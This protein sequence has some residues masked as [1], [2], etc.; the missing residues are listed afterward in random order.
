VHPT[1]VSLGPLRDEERGAA[2]R[3]SLDWRL[4]LGDWRNDCPSRALGCVP[5]GPAGRNPPRRSGVVRDLSLVCGAH[6]DTSRI[7]RR[8]KDPCDGR[9]SLRPRERAAHRGGRRRV[10]GLGRRR[11]RYGRRPG[12]VHR[13]SAACVHASA[14]DGR[15]RCPNDEDPRGPF[16]SHRGR[17]RTVASRRA[18]RAERGDRSS[19]ASASAAGRAFLARPMGPRR[20]DAAR[21]SAACGPVERRRRLDRGSDVRRRAILGPAPLAERH[22]CLCRVPRGRS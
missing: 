10:A 15:H 5:G 21:R 1:R 7:G 8:R 17:P 9:A 3:S 12:D 19:G 22:R 13:G 4:R 18:R 16:G 2:L 11:H 6:Q 14:S 20:G